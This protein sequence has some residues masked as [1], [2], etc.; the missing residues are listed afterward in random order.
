MKG[1]GER[2]QHLTG[3][4]TLSLCDPRGH[5]HLSLGG[6]TEPTVFVVAVVAG[7]GL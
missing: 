2:E 5:K 7:T 6:G 4:V 3:W 1:G